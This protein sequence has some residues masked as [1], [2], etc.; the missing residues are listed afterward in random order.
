[1]ALIYYLNDVAVFEEEVLEKQHSGELERL[2]SELSG[3]PDGTVY[4]FESGDVNPLDLV[5]PDFEPIGI[6]KPLSIEI[7]TVYSGDAPERWLGKKDLLVTSGVK[8]IGTY[9]SAPK[10]VNQIVKRVEDNR[11]YDPGAFNEGSTVVYYTPALDLNTI[12]CSFQL[13]A[14]TFKESTFEKISGLLAK[15]GVLPVFAPAASV[16]LIG[17]NVSS[18]VSSLGKALFESKPYFNGELPIRLDTPGRIIEKSRYIAIIDEKNRKE[19][20]NYAPKWITIGEI[21][22]I[23]LVSKIDGSEYDGDAPYILISLD[24]R[25]RDE[26]KE[27]KSTIASAAMIEKFYGTQDSSQSIDV[28]KD[29]MILYNDAKYFEKHKNQLLKLNE[30][31]EGTKEYEKAKLLLE[32]YKKNI[33]SSLFKENL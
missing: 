30:L 24:G 8:A 16:L 2:D 15:A 33:E 13:V 5:T 14:D 21:Q 6:G 31:E 3:N 22:R 27:F 32:T 1:M 7:L 20:I 4:S 29:A 25:Q 17:S 10:A 26:L 9:N 23:R 28:I 12:L 18:M 11:N 19:F